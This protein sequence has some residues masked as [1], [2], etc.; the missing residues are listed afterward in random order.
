MTETEKNWVKRTLTKS[1]S[2]LVVETEDSFRELSL[3]HFEHE[4]NQKHFELWLK[5]LECCC[6]QLLVHRD[7]DRTDLIDVDLSKEVLSYFIDKKYKKRVVFYVRNG[8]DGER[9]LIND[10]ET[11][12]RL[13]TI[14]HCLPIMQLVPMQL[15]LNARKYMPTDSSL[16]VELTIAE[17]RK[18]LV[19]SNVGPLCDAEEI[20]SITKEGIRGQNTKSYS[21][22]GVGLSE[23]QTILDL[24]DE[25]L[26]TTFDVDSESEVT[27]FNGY[28]HSIFKAEVTYLNNPEYSEIQPAIEDIRNKIPLFLIHNSM[29]IANSLLDICDH[30]LTINE[31][32]NREWREKVYR[33]RLFAS[34]LFKTVKECI[35]M[36]NSQNIQDVLGA[37]C[38]HFNVENAFRAIAK[39]LCK[40]RYKNITLDFTGKLK[41]KYT[42]LDTWD[43]MRIFLL[44]ICDLIMKNVR[45]ET[46]LEIDFEDDQIMIKCSDGAIIQKFANPEQTDDDEKFYFNMYEELIK[47]LQGKI[48][49]FNKFLTIYLPK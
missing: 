3:H 19:F 9:N 20:D 30:L 41:S 31:K 45:G 23:V 15:A 37:E 39:E 32:T 46:V 38:R 47:S 40:Y 48:G 12:S 13:F 4:D 16:E 2:Q 34:I 5:H 21:G 6:R 35:F 10:P 7:L 28:R 17:K 24:H 22:M 11:L 44:A 36:T 26:G 49:I 18:Y 29:D 27:E 25:W 43:G 8:H 1:I 14:N 33:L 42:N